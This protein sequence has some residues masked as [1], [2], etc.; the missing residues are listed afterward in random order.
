MVFNDDYIHISDGISSVWKGVGI[1]VIDQSISP[2][3]NYTDP[4]IFKMKEYRVY[5]YHSDINWAF[6]NKPKEVK[7]DNDIFSK[8]PN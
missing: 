4:S 1:M 7:T 6:V 2:H 3:A 5:N 8:Y